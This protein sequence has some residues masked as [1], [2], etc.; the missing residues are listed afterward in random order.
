MKLNDKKVYLNDF[1]VILNKQFEEKI[2]SVINN[3]NITK[4][5]CKLRFD[6]FLSQVHLNNEK[7]IKYISSEEK[8]RSG[9]LIIKSK[10]SS[11]F[12][13]F[14]I[15]KDL[16]SVF[17]IGIIKQKN[18]SFTRDLILTKIKPIMGYVYFV[19]SD[20]GFKI[21]YTTNLTTRLNTFGVKLP[22]KILLNSYIETFDYKNIELMLHKMLSHKRLNGEWFSLT[23][24]DFS[25]I[26]KIIKN[27]NLKR[28]I[29]TQ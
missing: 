8:E 17:S 4:E 2:Y 9:N 11:L 24:N 19:K 28:I 29:L 14:C 16:T 7:I 26:D 1:T 22:F 23:D 6:K 13:T 10:E 18:I 12:Y 15:N 20:Y 3:E 27:I 25:D 21:G 5:Y